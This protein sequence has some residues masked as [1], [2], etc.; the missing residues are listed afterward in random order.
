VVVAV[1]VG[2]RLQQAVQAVQAVV[3]KVVD[4]AVVL[5]EQQEL[6]I[7]VVVADHVLHLLVVLLRLAVPEVLE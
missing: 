4:P 7:Q 6:Q 1:V 2:F 3:V 5:L